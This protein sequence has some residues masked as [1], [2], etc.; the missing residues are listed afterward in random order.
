MNLNIYK[1]IEMIERNTHR[2]NLSN[3][4]GQKF[5]KSFLLIDLIQGKSQRYTKHCHQH[6]S[7]IKSKIF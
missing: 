1:F 4:R 7:E 2:T 6:G 3:G 5:Y